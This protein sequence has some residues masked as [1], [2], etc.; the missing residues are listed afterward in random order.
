MTR[1]QDYD[2]GDAIRLLCNTIRKIHHFDTHGEGITPCCRTDGEYILQDALEYLARGDTHNARIEI[3][4]YEQWR[5]SKTAPRRA[6][7]NLDNDIRF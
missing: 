5:D 7:N 2:G 3:A 6:D 4:R 1:Q